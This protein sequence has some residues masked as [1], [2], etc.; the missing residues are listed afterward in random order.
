MLEEV[1]ETAE[2]AFD[3]SAKRHL[4]VPTS[5]HSLESK[6]VD[7][8]GDE[9]AVGT[10]CVAKTLTDHASEYGLEPLLVAVFVIPHAL[11]GTSDAY[12]AAGNGYGRVEKI[13]I[14]ELPVDTI[15][16]YVDLVETMPPR[17]SGIF[18][19]YG[20]LQSAAL[21]CQRIHRPRVV[22]VVVGVYPSL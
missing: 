18:N 9:C 11:Q 14:R 7:M 21:D 2:D 8:V 3:R 20:A 1:V 10:R 16:K 6:S 4:V 12:L 13:Q 19:G 22:G 15:I 17:A 5:S